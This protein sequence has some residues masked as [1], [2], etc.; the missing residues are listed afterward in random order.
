MPRGGLVITVSNEAVIPRYI[1][2][3]VYG[4]KL[5]YWRDE[6]PNL[7]EYVRVLAA[8]ASCR[9][10]DHVFFHSR[11]RFVYGGRV[12]GSDTHGAFF[13]NGRRGFLGRR[14]DAPLVWDESDWAQQEPPALKRLDPA[15]RAAVIQPFLLRF[16]DELG[17]AG[18]WADEDSLYFGLRSYPYMLPTNWPS[19]KLVSVSPGEAELL[20]SLLSESPS[21]RYGHDDVGDVELADEPEPY[22]SQHGPRALG[23]M[24]VDDLLAALL[25]NPR[26][27]PPVIPPREA[28]LCHH[29]PISPYRPRDVPTAD[30]AW[31]S[32]S[33]LNDGT[34]PDG[35]VYLDAESAGAD[36]RRRIDA[37]HAWL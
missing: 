26:Q 33:R 2:A 35:L 14:A 37:Q 5:R 22:E 12:R 9:E 25:A 10:G 1:A 34:V 4:P 27:L 29:V 36:L 16:D 18:R 13:L 8:I 11:G 21:A 15:R 28:A 24:T 20:L 19:S 7:T 6:D 32:D 31:Y 30:I 3:G 17:L 23:A